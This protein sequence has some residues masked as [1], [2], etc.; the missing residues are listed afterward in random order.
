[1][2]LMAVISQTEFIQGQFAFD[3]LFTLHWIYIV[4]RRVAESVPDTAFVHTRNAAFQAVSAPEQYY[5]APLLKVERFL[6]V[7]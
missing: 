6:S 4:K 7:V 5:T 1:M 3:A 2:T